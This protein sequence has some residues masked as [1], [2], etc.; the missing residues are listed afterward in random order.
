MSIN[1]FQEPYLNGLCQWCSQRKDQALDLATTSTPDHQLPEGHLAGTSETRI[2]LEK[3]S[4]IKFILENILIFF[5]I[6]LVK[7]KIM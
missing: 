3:I 1:Y 5:H 2:G 4:P 7:V 6:Y